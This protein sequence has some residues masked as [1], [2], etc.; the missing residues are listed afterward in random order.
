MLLGEVFKIENQPQLAKFEACLKKEKQNDA[1]LKGLFLTID[2]SQILNLT[3]F[4]FKQVSP[5]EVESEFRKTYLRLPQ[6][7]LKSNQSVVM[8]MLKNNTEKQ[9]PALPIQVFTSS[10]NESLR[11][12]INKNQ[13]DSERV[14]CILLSRVIIQKDGEQPL[15]SS[16]C[17][18]EKTVAQVSNPEYIY[19]E[20]V[21]LCRIKTLQRDLP[22]AKANDIK[23]L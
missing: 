6:S 20:Y 13:E 8:G 3:I 17:D 11:E 18:G 2:T 10:T 15:A 14:H 22:Q 21:M 12:H 4:G 9:A 5:D 23:S 16:Y 19:P 1:I 7:L